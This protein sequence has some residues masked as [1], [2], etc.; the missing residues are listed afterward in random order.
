M[1]DKLSSPFHSPHRLPN[2]DG[3]AR[4]IHD[5]NPSTNL[6]VEH[7]RAGRDPAMHF[8][9]VV[10]GNKGRVGKVNETT[11]DILSSAMGGQRRSATGD[12]ESE[13]SFHKK[14]TA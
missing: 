11:P 10:P 3:D 5:V 1:K 6:N 8:V 9:E 7:D 2:R 4:D 13:A 14:G 12:Y